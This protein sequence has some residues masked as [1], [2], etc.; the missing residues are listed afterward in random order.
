M[1]VSSPEGSANLGEG[2]ITALTNLETLGVSLVK[3]GAN[4]K[5]FALTKSI[6]DVESS[7]D[8]SEVLVSIIKE[9]KVEESDKL[10]S[11]IAKSEL[12]VKSAAAAEGIAKLLSAFSDD[13][14]LAAVVKAMASDQSTSQDE[15]EDEDEARKAKKAKK[16]LNKAKASAKQDDDSDMD[17]DADSDQDED[18]DEDESAAR[19]SAKKSLTKALEK[20]PADVRASLEPIWKAQA[21]QNALARKQVAE[22]QAIV[23][24]ETDARITREWVSK[25][26]KELA[27]VPGQKP[28][29]IAKHLKDLADFNPKLADAHFKMLKTASEAVKKSAMFRDIG[30]NPSGESG[31]LSAEEQI[32]AKAQMFVEK[33]AGALT[34]EAAQE[35]VMKMFPD[36][37][38]QQEAEQNARILRAKGL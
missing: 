32:L 1:T 33:S 4:K 26:E 38:L 19:K 28:T 29:E 6:G 31:S 18:E 3:R 37:Y 35:K 36:L 11:L 2:N 15:D 17:S 30:V 21:E 9:G 25:A 34:I 22:L 8:I 13:P 14:K 27:Y 23:K 20:L 12:G 7:V 5:L 10:K 16:S 24:S